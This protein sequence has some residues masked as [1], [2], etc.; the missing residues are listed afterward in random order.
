MAQYVRGSKVSSK[1]PAAE[2]FNLLDKFKFLSIK[3]EE[4]EFTETFLSKE[5]N[6]DFWD[7]IKDNL[8]IS[9]DCSLAG[10]A[11]E[12]VLLLST[13]KVNMGKTTLVEQKKFL[14]DQKLSVIQKIRNIEV[15]LEIP[16]KC[17]ILS[18]IT[19]SFVCFNEKILLHLLQNVLPEKTDLF[20]LEP[21]DKKGIVF[22]KVF[23]FKGYKFQTISQ[24]IEK[25]EQV[26]NGKKILVFKV[27]NFFFYRP[28]K[29][30]FF[31]SL[32]FSNK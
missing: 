9:L 30:F 12:R 1:A 4:K 22:Q 28:K 17:L 13:K 19:D 25:G 5:G 14:D 24:V 32:Y 3:E 31:F 7:D 21:N 23:D 18:G 26:D 6:G 10:A 8:A 27:F 15:E 29:R 20:R 16:P 11:L 2:Y